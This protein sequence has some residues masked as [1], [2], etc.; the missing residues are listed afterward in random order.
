MSFKKIIKITVILGLFFL[1]YQNNNLQ[2]KSENLDVLV[3]NNEDMKK[4]KQ[5]LRNLDKSFKF[6]EIP[7]I[8]FLRIENPNNKVKDNIKNNNEVKYSGKI[9]SPII[10]ENSTES[11][12]K[13]AELSIEEELLNNL[14]WYV[15][16]LT[17]NKE[18]LKYSSGKNIKIGLIDSGVDSGHP[19]IK[20]SLNLKNAKSFVE[21]DSSIED[22]NGHG[23]MVSGVISQIAPKAEITPYKVMSSVDG[24]SLWTLQAMA[25]AINDKQD[26][27]NISLGTYKTK[28]IK[29]EK[30]TIEAFKR[31][32]KLAKKNNVLIISSAGNKQINLDDNYSNHR[33]LHLPGD[34]KDVI[35]VSATDKLDKLSEYSNTGSVIEF[36][37]PGGKLLIDE[38]G[39]LDAREMIYTAFPLKLSN[40]YSV[41]GI[42]NGY[43]LTYGTS[44]SA[45]G[46]TAV[47][48]DY[49]SYYQERLGKKPK[50]EQ[51]S[52]N[53]YKTV[54]DLGLKGKDNEY[55][56]GLPNLVKAYELLSKK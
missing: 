12:H 55:G 9:A 31:M 32:V 38:N 6:T 46:I 5:E 23:T 51:A 10:G 39:A 27:L 44:F 54:T 49:Y 17:I 20:D 7:E 1:L 25:K 29:D 37:A 40:P 8:N 2:A 30:I 42:P 34:I 48:A 14:T 43:T 11:V 22:K 33:V 18:S 56:Y 36:A 4:L 13:L 45:A 16:K 24:E 41:A 19:L 26:I 21:G 50:P 15:N 28:N 47:Y 35:T 3:S 52:K 53:L